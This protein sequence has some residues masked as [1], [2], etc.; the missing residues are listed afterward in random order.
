MTPS[1]DI[2][3][4]GKLFKGDYFLAVPHYS[5]CAGIAAFH[6][7]TVAGNAAWSTAHAYRCQHP[8]RHHNSDYAT[9]RDQQNVKRMSSS[10]EPKHV[11]TYQSTVPQPELVDFTMPPCGRICLKL[12]AFCLKA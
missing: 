10:T 12:I 1:R 11:T 5:C 3:G 4:C 6:I 9:V 8:S 2:K 7:P